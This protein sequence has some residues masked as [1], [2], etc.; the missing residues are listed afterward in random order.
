M[1]KYFLGIDQGT[2][3]TTTLL[4]DENWNSVSTGQVEHRQIYPQ[5][6]WVEHDPEEILAACSASVAEA[7]RKYPSCN[8]KDIV[9]VGISNQGET[10]TIWEKATG[11][12]IYNAIV[13]QDR[14]TSEFCD[15]LQAEHGDYI[16]NVTGLVPDAYFSASKFR[17][18]LD[19]VPGAR[20]RASRGELMAGT[21]DSFLIYR[22]SGKKSWVTDASTAGC[23]MLMRMKD[24]LWDETMLE[25]CD[26][27][28]GLL[29]E[30]ND[31]SKIY[32]FTD[33]EVFCGLRIPI[34]ASLADAHAAL[35]AQNCLL[36]GDIKSTYGTGVF[37]NMTT[38]DKLILSKNGLTSSL[39]WQIGG[40]RTYALGGSAYIA[41]GAVQWLRDGLGIVNRIGDSAAL[42]QSVSDTGDVYFV[43]AFNGL[44]APWWDQYARGLIIG[45]TG[46]TSKAQIV[47]AVLESIA[48]QVYDN[49][50]TMQLD[51]GSSI[52]VM[53]A[54]GGPVDNEF[55]MQF[56]A[57]IL[58]VPIQIPTEKESSA[59]G[60]AFLAALAVGEFSS[61]HDVKNCL[62]PKRQYLPNMSADER[63]SRVQRWHEAVKRS[64]KWAN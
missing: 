55:L 22:L 58:G 7:L 49:A 51:S 63:L 45:I 26:I 42:A 50:M 18:I 40:K 23:T 60:A 2:T 20:E 39:P 48:F 62:K 53:K 56:Q 61:I 54:D 35:C 43:P 46:G 30:I 5:P 15:V 21:L 1:T 3:G 27:P 4:I 47:R 44:A 37:M 19:N 52:S 9:S 34:A 16:R 24:G 38:G 12:P 8:P 33:P 28:A 41:G 36:P 59:Y 13:W 14:R 6:G 64:L 57:D 11:R 29:P 25:L 17:W 32:G 31:C 10:C